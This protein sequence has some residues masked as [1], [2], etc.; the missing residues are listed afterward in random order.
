MT[1][2]SG[3]R[4]FGSGGLRPVSSSG[5]MRWLSTDHGGGLAPG[6][7]KALA[8]EAGEAGHHCDLRLAQGCGTA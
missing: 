6:A 8:S 3:G 2:N 5:G 7:R 4:G 1:I